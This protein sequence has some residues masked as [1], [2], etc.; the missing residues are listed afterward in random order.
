MHF[1]SPLSLHWDA[2]IGLFLD[3]WSIQDYECYD[4]LC[5][6]VIGIRKNAWEMDKACFEI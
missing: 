4:I 2:R 6:Y 3:G 5:V 1:Y